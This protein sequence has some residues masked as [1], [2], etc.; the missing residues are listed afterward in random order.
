[1]VLWGATK[2]DTFEMDTIIMVDGSF[3]YSLVHARSS[4][5]RLEPSVR[6]LTEVSGQINSP[7]LNNAIEVKEVAF[8]DDPRILIVPLYINP[9]ELEKTS[10]IEVFNAPQN[11]YLFSEAVVVNAKSGRFGQTDFIR[12]ERDSRYIKVSH[13]NFAFITG[14]FDPGKGRFSFFS[15]GRASW[16]YG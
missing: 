12:D 13:T 10:E 3:A 11:P 9:K 14:K 16:H 4:P 1:M 8:M 2:K 6:K 15:K 7:K 5:F